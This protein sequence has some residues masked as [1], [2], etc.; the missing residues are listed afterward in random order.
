MILGI[1]NFVLVF[2]QLAGGL[3]WVGISFTAHR[4]TGI[5]L[6]VTATLHGVL[7]VLAG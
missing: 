6:A 2:M 5:A 7:A 3:R 1:V 4:R